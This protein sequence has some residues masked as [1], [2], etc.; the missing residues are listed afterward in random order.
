METIMFCP[1]CEAEYQDHVMLCADCHVPLVSLPILQEILV[2]KDKP[3]FVKGDLD[4]VQVFSTQDPGI[5]ALAK[6]L[7][8]EAGIPAM[9][10]N[11][12]LQDLFGFGRLNFNPV[13]GDVDF[14]VNSEDR[15]KAAE[16]LA[17]FTTDAT[18]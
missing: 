5:V 1:K 16:V 4:L 9:V 12:G 14:F 2:A 13:S 7:L 15:V 11:E 17:N 18:P 6:S 8:D 3:K 10:R